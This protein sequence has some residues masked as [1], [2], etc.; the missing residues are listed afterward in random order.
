MGPW[1]NDV[2]N[3]RR[4]LPNCGKVPTGGGPPILP[5]LCAH[6][7]ERPLSYRRASHKNLGL[8]RGAK[9][10]PHGVFTGNF[11]STEGVFK[12]PFLVSRGLQNNSGSRVV[13]SKK[14]PARAF[15]FV[16]QKPSCGEK[17][18]PQ[19]TTLSSSGGRRHSSLDPR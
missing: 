2:H 12:R 7:G 4:R 5:K 15:F 17:A 9:I 14:Q 10:C 3:I 16:G 18:P 6:V 1:D 8:N 13:V 11:L 19:T